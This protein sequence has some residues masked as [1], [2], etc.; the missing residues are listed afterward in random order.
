M[1][2]AGE[3]TKADR[4]FE[5]LGAGVFAYVSRQ[6]IGAREAPAAIDGGTAKWLLS[7]MNA[8]VGV[9]KLNK[10][11]LF[12]MYAHV[13]VSKL[14]KRLLAWIHARTRRKFCFSVGYT[15]AHVKKRVE[16]MV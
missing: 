11:L 7:W 14:D 1:V 16:I 4:T 6:L 13:G 5:R 10:R 9:S 2:G 12:W 3:R 8:H 15:I